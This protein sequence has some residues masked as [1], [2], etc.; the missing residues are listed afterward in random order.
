MRNA[1]V[2]RKTAETD[3]TINI[4]LDGTGLCQSDSGVPFLDHMLDQLA[5]H[6]LIDIS[7]SATGDNFIDDHHTVEDVA[8]VLGMAI[9]RA[10]G[11]KQ[12]IYRYGHYLL[13]MD[14]A[15][16]RVALDLSGRPFLSW[17]VDVPAARIG[18][19][20]TELLREFFQSFSTHSGMALHVDK[21]RGLNS[22]HI[23]EAT[24]KAVARALR[25]AVEP[26]ARRAGMIP[27]TKGNL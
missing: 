13:P 25:M 14:D 22:H 21:I 5:A 1:K 26:D 3:V 16:I 24:F 6:S 8:I 27:S 4:N 17:S 2:S 15:L 9:A 23:A 20:D 11:D 12:G 10:L 18:T 19:F 7:L